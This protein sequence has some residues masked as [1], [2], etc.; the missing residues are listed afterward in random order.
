MKKTAVF[1][2]AACI[3]LSGCGVGIAIP[4]SDSAVE[5][6]TDIFHEQ[7]TFLNGTL[8]RRM[9]RSAGCGE[10]FIRRR[11]IRMADLPM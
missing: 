7:S 1:T 6:S 10:R 11:M 4:G 3:L 5:L 2:V 8:Q 9:K